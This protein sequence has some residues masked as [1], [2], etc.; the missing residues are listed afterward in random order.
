MILSPDTNLLVYAHD[1]REPLK[2]R[3]ALQIVAA[4]TEREST[5][6]GLQVAGEL[7]AVL[8]RRLKQTP[9]LA[10]EAVLST[11]RM[12]GTFG[13]AESDVQTAL[14]LSARGVLSHWD[15]LLVSAAARAGC[16][17]LISEDMQDGF[18]FGTLEIVSPFSNDGIAPRLTDLLGP[19]Q[20]SD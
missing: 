14:A 13:Y 12:F 9:E 16:T 1:A 19:L 8:T 17:H 3:S 18:R 11:L 6:V 15:G 20:T 4:L 2:R 7:H 10:C 5:L